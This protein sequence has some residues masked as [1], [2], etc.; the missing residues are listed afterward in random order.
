VLTEPL[1]ELRFVRLSAPLLVRLPAV[2][3][4]P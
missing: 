3:N 2:P 4:E 1:L